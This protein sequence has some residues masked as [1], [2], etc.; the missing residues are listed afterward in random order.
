VVSEEMVQTS[1]GKCSL[2]THIA[3]QI[4]KTIPA[5]LGRAPETVSSPLA[6]P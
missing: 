5:D 4:F 2:N 1:L 3:R 6:I